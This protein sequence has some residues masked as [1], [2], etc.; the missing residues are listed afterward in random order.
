[1]IE[2]DARDAHAA[3]GAVQ[4]GFGVAQRHV[5]LES[6]GGLDHRPHGGAAHR[7]IRQA[8]AVLGQ[9]AEEA[10]LALIAVGVGH[11]LDALHLV[12]GAHQRVVGVAAGDDQ[13]LVPGAEGRQHA[14]RP[15]GMP[16]AVS[17]E[18]VKDAHGDPPLGTT[19]LA[20]SREDAVAFWQRSHDVWPTA[21]YG[22]YRFPCPETA[23]A[24]VPFVQPRIAV[25]TTLRRA[26]P[27]LALGVFAGGD[28]YPALSAT[29][30][31]TVSVRAPHDMLDP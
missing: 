19:L 21:G 16:A 6:P 31:V 30:G 7:Q 25:D 22:T 18:P 24:L 5:G 28:I 2:A 8:L 13:H 20:A 10:A 29:F 3:G 14:Q 26:I 4:P 12:A 9:R 15:R 11:R 17:V 1:V 27:S 23:T